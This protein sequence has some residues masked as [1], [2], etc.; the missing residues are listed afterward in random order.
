MK[1]LLVLATK[2]MTAAATVAAS[3]CV[4]MTVIGC[5]FQGDFLKT[6]DFPAETVIRSSVS[7]S[8]LNDARRQCQIYVG[9]TSIESAALS[10][11][12]RVKSDPAIKRFNASLQNMDPADA[13]E[14]GE[15]CKSVNEARAVKQQFL[16]DTT[17]R[18][19]TEYANL[20]P[21]AAAKYY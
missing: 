15:F 8:V 16:A 5:S 11:Q 6:P 20:K 9:K 1:N 18:R 7:V 14:L 19:K 21:S 4:A 2:N 12:E 10:S 13:V 3:V 17:P